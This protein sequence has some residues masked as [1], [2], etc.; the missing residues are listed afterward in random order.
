MPSQVSWVLFSGFCLVC[1][2]LHLYLESNE[3]GFTIWS[4]SQFGSKQRGR[5]LC[6]QSKVC[7]HNKCW[8]ASEP[9]LSK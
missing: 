5:G 9:V 4:A 2:I 6:V 8:N 7:M 3:E 1:N